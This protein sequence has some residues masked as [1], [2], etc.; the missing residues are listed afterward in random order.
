MTFVMINSDSGWVLVV[1]IL[2]ICS[3]GTHINHIDTS[4]L[5]TMG[6]SSVK[7]NEHTKVGLQI[8]ININEGIEYTENL[9]EY[10]ENHKL[11]IEK[12]REFKKSYLF[13]RDLI[14]N[15]FPQLILKA[16]ENIKAINIY[17]SFSDQIDRFISQ[18]DF[19]L[20]IDLADKDY[21]AGNYIGIEE[22]FD[23]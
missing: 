18:M 12:I 7:T 15:S 2:Y 20:D 14:N 6:E 17:K 19:Y 3:M 11:T 9:S 8:E 23:V 10:C 21:K 4:K 13:I 16:G 5:Y 22:A 1:G